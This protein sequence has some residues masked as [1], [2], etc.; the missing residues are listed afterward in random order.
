MSEVA[1]FRPPDSRLYFRPAVAAVRPWLISCPATS[2][3][4]SGSALFAPS[5]YVMQ[6]QLSFQN[7]LT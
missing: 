5:P 7:A 4:V 3:E 6:K 2:S 1:S